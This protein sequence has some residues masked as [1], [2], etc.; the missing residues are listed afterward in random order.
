MNMVQI[1]STLS[2]EGHFFVF[3]ENET[4]P[5]FEQTENV[6]ALGYIL[7]PISSEPEAA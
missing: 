1:V 4:Y 3:N 2:S 7:C 5:I 6:E